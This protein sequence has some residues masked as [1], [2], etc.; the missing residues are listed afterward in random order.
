V[1]GNKVFL[2][3]KKNPI[4]SKRAQALIEYLIMFTAIV[5]VFI[6]FLGGR[7]S[8]FSKYFSRALEDSSGG[9]LAQTNYI[10]QSA[11]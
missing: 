7:N 2:I 10:L 4:L 8:I 5:G 1:K 6:L 9:I 11:Q 3:V